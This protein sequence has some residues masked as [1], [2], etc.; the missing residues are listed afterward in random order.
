[1][2]WEKAFP[3]ISSFDK[4][5]VSAGARQIPQ[6]LTEQLAEGGRM[7]IPVGEQNQQSLMLVTKQDGLLCYSDCGLCAFVPLITST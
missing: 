1:M 6:R 3:A 7:V 2:G 5:V 4:I